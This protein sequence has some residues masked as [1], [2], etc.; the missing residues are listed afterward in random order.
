[1]Y[2]IKIF[3]SIKEINQKS[4]DSLVE[5]DKIICSYNFLKAVEESHINDCNFYYLVIYNNAHKIVAHTWVY[6]MSMDIVT[7]IKGTSKNILNFIRE[8]FPKFLIVK[9]TECGS[10][11]ALGNIISISIKSGEKRN[12]ILDL[13]IDTTIDIAK[14]NNANFLIIRD[15][16]KKDLEFDKEFL[17]LGMFQAYNLPDVQMDIHWETFD[18]YLKSLRYNYRRFVKKC[19]NVMENEKI[20]V[21]YVE[22]FKTYV[23][24]LRKLYYNCYENAAE[25]RREILTEDFFYK[26]NEYM[27]DKSGVLLLKK[28]QEVIGFAYFLLDDYTARLLYVG[29]NYETK[30]K[31]LTYFN[32]FYQG[33]KFA[34]DNK[35]KKIELGVTTYEF[36]MKMGGEVTSLYAYIKHLNGILNF[37]LKKT[38]KFLFPR[39]NLEARHPFNDNRKR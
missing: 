21:E 12:H 7:L 2:K 13:I 5:K 8:I 29:F 35:F 22:N 14:K 30:K 19:L 17:R 31:Y 28:G 16:Y 9:I 10:P 24:I 36:K 32:I 20:K 27:K 23:P 18:E 33:L 6:T 3:K 39:K 4:W 1:M 38:N 11:I 15:F 25:Y 37:I 26:T 34:I